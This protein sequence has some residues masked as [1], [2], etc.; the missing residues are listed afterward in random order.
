[1]LMKKILA[2]KRILRTRVTRC[3]A[4]CNQNHVTQDSGFNL[5]KP[6]G[7]QELMLK[8]FACQILAQ[9]PS[10]FLK[11]IV[12]KRK[13]EQLFSVATNFSRDFIT[14]VAEVTCN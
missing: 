1:M 3:S 11:F 8:N 14:V 12:Y 4:T 9:N 10:S 13:V 2:I 5:Y 7:C 6:L